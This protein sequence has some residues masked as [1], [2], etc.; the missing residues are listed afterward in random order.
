MI[1]AFFIVYRYKNQIKTNTFQFMR[2]LNSFRSFCMLTILIL[3]V[4]N[5]FNLFADNNKIENTQKPK[6]FFGNGINIQPSYYNLGNPECSWDL[7]G[8]F[9]GI[10]SIRIEIDP[11]NT[12]VDA[13][14]A[15]QWL[16]NAHK[17]G[18]KIIATYHDWK[19]LG[20]DNPEFVMKAANWWL[21]NYDIL[22]K[23]LL[24]LNNGVDVPFTLNMINEW[25]SHDI[26]AEL[27]AKTYNDAIAI[28]RQKYSG[29]IIIDCPGWGQGIAQASSA[30]LGTTTNGIKLNDK[31]II[32][33][34]HIYP[35]GYNMAKK[36]W[37]QK[38]DLDDLEK[39]KLPCIIGEFGNYAKG[40]GQCNWLDV[41]NYAKSK[42]WD[43]LGW[44]W[45]GD[46][47]DE[48]NQ[49]GPMNMVTPAWIADSTAT[50]RTTSAYFDLI[51]EIISVR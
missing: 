18:L 32:L 19:A 25:G 17:L 42:G 12:K 23:E 26:S 44:A 21:K 5:S 39:S 3:A 46:N 16:Y 35:N 34:A 9:P 36:R 4:F 24:R 37:L 27:Y 2:K 14:Q 1:R 8:K 28:V 41:V 47:A 29:Y 49:T 45:N 6:S 15:A 10:K 31:K 43:V 33:S 13:I 30:A 50:K 22:K 38:E 7:I 51:Y 48:L 11:V 20:S 40:N